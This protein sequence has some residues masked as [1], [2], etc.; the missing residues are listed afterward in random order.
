MDP[1]LSFL[2]LELRFLS[3][4]VTFRRIFFDS[5]VSIPRENFDREKENEAQGW[6][7]SKTIRQWGVYERS[8]KGRRVGAVAS[9][10]YEK[11]DPPPREK[12]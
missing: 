7:V 10:S 1:L 4:A 5:L 6:A 9:N 11:N 8:V 3:L 2:F 12:D